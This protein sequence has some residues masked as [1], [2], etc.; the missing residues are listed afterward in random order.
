MSEERIKIKDITTGENAG[1]IVFNQGLK[2]VEHVLYLV[3]KYQQ[4]GRRAG[5]ASAKTRAEVTG[6]MKKLYKQKGTGNARSGSV[7][8]PLRR[9]G[10]VVFGPK[11]RNFGI[12]LNKKMVKQAVLTLLKKVEDRCFVLPS[13]LNDGAKTKVVAQYLS[14]KSD[15]SRPR[16]LFVLEN[17][18]DGMF[19]ACRNIDN[20]VVVSAVGLELALLASA[21]VVSFSPAAVSRIQELSK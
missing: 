9:G 11:P 19:Q 20:S 1:E 12:S 3:S 16:V 14:G 10:G 2:D 18:D 6:S 15:A 8:N 13:A 21:D 4:A 5:T 17:D 7:K